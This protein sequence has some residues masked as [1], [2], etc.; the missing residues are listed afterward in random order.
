MQKEIDAADC[1][2]LDVMKKNGLVVHAV[3]AA[4]EAQWKSATEKAF[5]QLV[6]KSF[7]KDSYELVRKNLDAYRSA[8]AH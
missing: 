3:P 2:A 1:Q 4:V 8:H 5:A 7:D 6:G